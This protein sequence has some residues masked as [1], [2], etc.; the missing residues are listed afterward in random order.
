VAELD[1]EGAAGKLV[2]ARAAV[3]AATTDAEREVA[4]R[5]VASLE[6]MQAAVVN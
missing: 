5:R 4:E 2:E 1:V 6:A 3:T